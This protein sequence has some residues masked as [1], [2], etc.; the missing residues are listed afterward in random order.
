MFYGL[1]FL[2]CCLCGI[3]TD[4]HTNLTKKAAYTACEIGFIGKLHERATIRCKMSPLRHQIR[5]TKLL[6]NRR[7]LTRHEDDDDDDDGEDE[8][9]LANGW[10]PLLGG[11]QPQRDN[12]P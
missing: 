9:Q 4:Y 7:Q 1:N 6:G 10:R 3:S 5:K 2:D 12:C 11:E 8:T